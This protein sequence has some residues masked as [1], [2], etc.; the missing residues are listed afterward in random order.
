A[1]RPARA[2]ARE[3]LE[4]ACVILAASGSSDLV[5]ADTSQH[6]LS[7]M[8]ASPRGTPDMPSRV[9]FVGAGALP[10][11]FAV[12]EFAAAAVGAA[13]LAVSDLLRAHGGRSHQVTVD[14]RLGSLW[15]GCS[16]QPVGWALPAAREPMEGGYYAVD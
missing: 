6:F 3:S 4:P 10:S 16:I 8:W 7:S 1:A 14:R 9:E 13:G 5:P 12:A 2:S 15:Y 11:V